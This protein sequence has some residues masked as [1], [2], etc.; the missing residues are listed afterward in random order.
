ML[1]LHHAV[2][3]GMAAV[4]IMGALFDL[5]S[6]AGDP[7]PSVW[8]PE[9]R[10]TRHALRA[11]HLSRATGAATRVATALLEPGRARAA[12]H[13]AWRLTRSYAGANRDL[14]APG[15]SL[16]RPVEQG[17]VV[18]VLPLD[19]DDVKAVAHAHDAKVNDVVLDLWIGGLRA[20]LRSR[21]EPVPAELVASIPA[22]LRAVASPASVDNQTGFMATALP[23]ADGDPVRRLALI[24][25]RTRTIKAE[26]HPEAI[27]GFM[28]A[29]AATPIAHAYVNH[30]RTSNTIVTNV[31]GPPVPVFMFGARVLEIW[32][33]IELVGNIGL[34]CCA[35]SYTGRLSLVV[36]A[37][38][39]AFPD[40][41]V[42][43]DGVA[44]EWQVFAA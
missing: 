2:A 41:D 17:R 43:M 8:R 24:A 32:P 35:F 21:G 37:D 7:E 22:T 18:R 1:K 39:N 4:A 27:A 31:P 38:A 36:T 23:A 26:Q 44:R 28:A 34:I 9:P 20:L 19:L 13:R 15:T 11:D 16:N 6:D 33:V 42:V 29:L 25:D 40:V 10:P 12:A 30:Q 14:R 5:S 3:D